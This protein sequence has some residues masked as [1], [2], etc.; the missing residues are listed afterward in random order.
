MRRISNYFLTGLII[1]SLSFIVACSGE[2]EASSESGSTGEGSDVNLSVS[3]YLSST[4]SQVTNVLEPFFE[5]VEEKTEGRVTADYYTS[6]A[7]G[8]AD[9]QFDMA[10]TGVADFVLSNH[11]YAVGQ[12]PL[13]G[14]GDLPF[15]GRSA[16][17]ASKILWEIQEQFPEISE[18]HEGTKIAWLLKTDTYQVFTTEKKV[19]HPT[20]LEGLRIRTPSPA[21]NEILELVGATPVNMPMGDVYEGMQRGVIDGALAPVSVVKN[22]QLGDVTKYITMGDFWTQSLYA[23]FN[24]S[25]WDNLSPEDQEIVEGMIGEEMA[26]KSGQVYDADAEAGMEMA[27]EEGVEIVELSDDELAEWEVALEPMV[28]GWIDDMESQGL[29][30]QEVYDAALNASKQN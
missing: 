29:P 12:F 15:M 7:L 30:G 13:T 1:I 6:N 28:Q 8:T 25:T 4:H 17:E 16:E 19:V 24:N 27:I 21:G 10:Q 26:I 23:V 5:E 3:T 22:F 18:E 9:A 20:D 14:V 2:K 11:G